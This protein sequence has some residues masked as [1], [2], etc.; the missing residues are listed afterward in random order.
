MRLLSI[1]QDWSSEFFSGPPQYKTE[2]GAQYVGDAAVA[3]LHAETFGKRVLLLIHGYNV[4]EANVLP[5]YADVEAGLRFNGLLGDN[6]PYQI[7]VGLLWPGF[8]NVGFA[9]AIHNANKSS[10]ILRDILVQLRPSWL[11]IETHSLGAR[12]G[13]GCANGMT[14]DE[15]ILTSPAVAADSL[16]MGS[17]FFQATQ[18]VRSTQVCFSR[19]DDVLGSWYRYFEMPLHWFQLSSGDVALGLTGP[20]D[21]TKCVSTVS[22]K[23]FSDTIHQHGAWRSEPTFPQRWSVWERAVAKPPAA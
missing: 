12:V 11:A 17:E 22:A 21:P 20:S 10:R 7:L 3:Q 1:R 5:A 8:N 16:E 2:G 15:L 9:S 23:D 6:A 14:L 13:L 19:N 4:L 18:H